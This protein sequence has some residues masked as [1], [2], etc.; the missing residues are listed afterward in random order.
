MGRD[1][2]V[3]GENRS[4]GER[5][6]RPRTV[7]PSQGAVPGFRMA[8]RENRQSHQE[9]KRG[10]RRRSRIL[11]RQVLPMAQGFDASRSAM[12]GRQKRRSAGRAQQKPNLP[13]LHVRLL[14]QPLIP[15]PCKDGQIKTGAPTGSPVFIKDAQNDR[16]P[17]F[18]ELDPLL[19]NRRSSSQ[20]AFWVGRSG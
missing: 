9:S 13:R 12:E 17:G 19:A 5:P 7:S 11:R 3:P 16:K 8:A 15:S 6:R 2:P 10:H 14:P 4:M 18:L 1:S 20:R